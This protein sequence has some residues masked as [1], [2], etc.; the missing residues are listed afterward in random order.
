MQAARTKGCSLCCSQRVKL[1][2]LLHVPWHRGCLTPF[3]EGVPLH[4][5]YHHAALVDDG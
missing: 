5:G 3:A 1:P 4:C 2:S